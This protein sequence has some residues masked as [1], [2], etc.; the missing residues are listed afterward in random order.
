MTKGNVAKFE[1]RCN[2]DNPKGKCPLKTKY[3]KDVCD[4]KCIFMKEK[5]KI[6][7]TETFQIQ[8]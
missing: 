4:I 8:K 3:S 1:M 5:K 2:T 6:H 7:E